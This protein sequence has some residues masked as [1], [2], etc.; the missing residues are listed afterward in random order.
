M[1][2]ASLLILGGASGH[3]DPVLLVVGAGLAL[4]LFGLSLYLATRRW[5]GQPRHPGF[6]WAMAGLAGYYLV[7][8]IVAA[9]AGLEY[10][11]AALLA[12]V[13]PMTA[14]ALL[15]AAIRAKTVESDGRLRDASGDAREDPYPGIGM[16]D[17]T[18]LGD[19]PEHSEALED[20]DYT[21]GG[22]FE[23]ARQARGRG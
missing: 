9:T 3:G 18:P 13:I 16:D 11:V 2:L 1:T 7:A 8:A 14:L 22:R 10:A 15:V 12:G 19:T 5:G 21:P 23:H 4:M 17:E 6:Y 20:P